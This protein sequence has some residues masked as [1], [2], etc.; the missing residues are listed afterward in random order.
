M[1]VKSEIEAAQSFQLLATPST[2]A[3]Q[4]PQSIG[5]SRQEYWSGVPLPSLGTRLK[6]SNKSAVGICMGCL[7]HCSE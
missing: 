2:A 1:N 4:A 5:F 6:G 3:L 7:C